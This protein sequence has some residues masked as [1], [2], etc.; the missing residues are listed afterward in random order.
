[1]IVHFSTG[2]QQTDACVQAVLDKAKA[3]GLNPDLHVE[4][5]GTTSV[6]EIYLK[7]D[8][9]K[10]STVPSHVFENMQGVSQVVRRSVARVSAYMNGNR[11]RH[12][13]YIG[14]S[15]IGPKHPCLLVSGPCSI[16]KHIGQV[17]E[18]L[19]SQGVYHV[20]GCYMKPR[21][22]ADSFR[23]FGPNALRRFMQA[24]KTNGVRSIWVEVIESCDIDEVRQIRD[25]VGY[26]GTIVLWVGARNIMGAYRLLQKLGEQK[27]FIVMLKHSNMIVDLDAFIKQASFVLFGPMW[28]NEAEDGAAVLDEERSK[29]DGNN[30]LLFCVRGLQKQ[31]RLDPHR[32]VPNL[33][34]IR[35]IHNRTWVPACLDPSHI[36]G[37][38]N[39]VLKVLRDGL[40]YHPDVVMIESHVNR[41]LALTDNDQLLDMEQLAVARCMIDEHNQRLV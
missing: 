40:A 30:R 8:K 2:V 34:W 38:P 6:F 36:G 25:E 7:D 20:R 28:W 32:N 31:D 19:V 37:E 16:D 33:H 21:S 5:G 26:A 41:Q 14:G 13:F 17:I 39:L 10:A 29:L 4:E 22:E 11:E 18:A 23:G 1:M 35:E 27:E 9:V 15:A 12:S 3:H 24:A